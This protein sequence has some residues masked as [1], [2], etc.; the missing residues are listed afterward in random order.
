M[1]KATIITIIILVVGVMWAIHSAEKE[2]PIG[3]EVTWCDG[4]GTSITGL[5]E[6]ATTKDGK[7]LMGYKLRVKDAR[8]PGGEYIVGVTEKYILSVKK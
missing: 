7:P 4:T 3:S 8:A 5:I 2:I 1:I 6:L